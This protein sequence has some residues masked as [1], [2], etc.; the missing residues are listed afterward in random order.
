MVPVLCVKGTVV[1]CMKENGK[2]INPMG[3]ERSSSQ[4]RMTATRGAIRVESDTAWVS[5]CG[6]METSIPATGTPVRPYYSPSL[7]IMHLGG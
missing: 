3:T 1:C 7:C 6:P 5:T 2:A 4:G